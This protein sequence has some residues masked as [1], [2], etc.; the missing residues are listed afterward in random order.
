MREDPRME[1]PPR[2]CGRE[3]RP[4]RESFGAC[5][6]GSP[7]PC[8]DASYPSSVLVSRRAIDEVFERYALHECRKISRSDLNDLVLCCAQVIVAR[9]MRRYINIRCMPERVIGGGNTGLLYRWFYLA[10]S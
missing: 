4:V 3:P 6:A 7:C 10:R 8:I 1:F 9:D 2:P 5:G